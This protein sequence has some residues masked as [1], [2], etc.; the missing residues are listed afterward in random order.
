L[1]KE[2]ATVFAAVEAAD[3]AKLKTALAALA[4]SPDRYRE[5]MG[6]LAWAGEHGSRLL[7]KMARDVHTRGFADAIVAADF[8][9]LPPPPPG[10]LDQHFIDFEILVK[11]FIC[12]CHCFC[13]CDCG[14]CCCDWPDICRWRL[15]CCCGLLLVGGQPDGIPKPLRTCRIDFS[16]EFSVTKSATFPYHADVALAAGGL[17]PGS[18]ATTHQDGGTDEINVAGLTGKLA[19]AQTPDGHKDTHKAGGT[20]EIN[21]AGLTGKLATAQTPEG[22]KDTHAPGGGDPVT[23]HALCGIPAASLARFDLLAWKADGATDTWQA[24]RGFVAGKVSGV[25]NLTNPV[26]M[27]TLPGATGANT[28]VVASGWG[29]NGGGVAPIVAEGNVTAADKIQFT[30]KDKN[31]APYDQGTWSSLEIRYIVVR[32][33]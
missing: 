27:P 7:G 4:A 21:V 8:G 22:H 26:T 32:T 19:T 25:V 3:A 11:E 14:C 1:P 15:C 29:D 2:I 20:D 24:W 13:H 18:H 6:G 5:F 33:A 9:K 30:V 12:W 10:F 16:G 28:I 17:P 31:G 23:L